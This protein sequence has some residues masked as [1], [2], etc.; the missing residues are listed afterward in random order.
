MRWGSKL[1][2]L[3]ILAVLGTAVAH[4]SDAPSVGRKTPVIAHYDW[5]GV[6]IGLNGGAGVG[7]SGASASVSGPFSALVPSD[8]A[9]RMKGWLLGGQ[10]GARWQRGML[11]YGVEADID[12]TNIENRA[13]S[14]NTVRRTFLATQLADTTSSQTN[15]SKLKWL[16]TVTGNVGLAVWERVLWSVKGGLAFGEV[17]WDNSANVSTTTLSPTGAAFC[18]GGVISCPSGG[19]AAS[20]S[21]T[22]YGWTLGS[23]LEVALDNRWSAKGEVDYVDL[24]SIGGV[25]GSGGTTAT[26]SQ[27][28]HL[29]VAKGGLNFRF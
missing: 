2:A 8:P 28:V 19:G 27:N 13:S 29:W 25:F 24:G 9:D 16:S 4:A 10:V 20:E 17:Q 5:T 6:Y 18:A 14:S 7:S 21:K 12:W 1:A 11:V 15:G 22:K 23:V 26:G 3:G